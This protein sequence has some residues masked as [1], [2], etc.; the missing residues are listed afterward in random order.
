[1]KIAKQ[2]DEMLSGLLRLTL[3]ALLLQPFVAT[4]A[5]EE[6]FDLLQIGTIE[7]RNVTI[8]T[9]NK[10]YIFLLHSKGMT[11]IK[12]ADLSPELRLKLGY[13]DPAAAK[14]RSNNPE[15]WARQTRSKIEVPQVKKVQAQ[16][17]G[18]W[19]PGQLREKFQLPP[20]TQ[21]T[22][23]IVAGVLLAFYLF[24]SFCCMLICRKAGLEPGTLVWV[25][26][27]QL[28]PLLKAAG[29]SPWWFLG[30]L[31]P[32]VNLVAQVLW[33][34]K[35]TQARG[36]NFLVALF[37]IFPLSSPFAALYLAFSGSRRARREERRVE[38][39][40]LEAA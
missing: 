33:C 10:N 14:P 6:K 15:A 5:L 9:R 40:T 3:L 8:T 32:G 19:S 27:L 17:A 18:L 30:F 31:I 25:P 28:L 37:L 36:K 34:I 20:V 24:H 21:S 2:L 7:Y 12:V 26:L 11:N 23:L 16:L 1:M 13:D 38:I 4:A 35:I 39:M 22:L 29:M